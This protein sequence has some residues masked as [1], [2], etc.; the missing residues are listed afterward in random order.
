M[1]FLIRIKRRR[2]GVKDPGAPKLGLQ[3]LSPNDGW[4]PFK[5][6]PHMRESGDPDIE[7]RQVGAA[8]YAA[9]V[10]RRA[11]EE[12]AA[13]REAA[14]AKKAQELVAAEAEAKAK[15]K[16]APRVREKAKLSHLATGDDDDDAT[17]DDGKDDAGD[18]S[19][20]TDDDATGDDGKSGDE[21]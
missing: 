13:K 20:A 2:I 18:A 17:G 8:Q 7:C 15:A 4:V 1:P 6:R 10:K 9:A 21:V 5:K 3:W 14:A 11:K 12:A 16:A 19:R